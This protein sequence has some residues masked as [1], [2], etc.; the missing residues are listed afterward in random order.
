MR[1]NTNINAITALNQ[2]TKN[3]ALAGTSMI[4]MLLQH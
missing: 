2:S 4:L 1:I 3:T